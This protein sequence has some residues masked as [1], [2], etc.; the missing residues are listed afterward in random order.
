MKQTDAMNGVRGRNQEPLSPALCRHE[1]IGLA[2]IT[3][4][5][6]LPGFAIYPLPSQDGPQH[7]FT[8][9]ALLHLEDPALGFG[10]YFES[11]TPLSSQGFV[12]LLVGLGK[13]LPFEVAERTAVGVLLALFPLFGAIYAR[14]AH[15]PVLPVA[16]MLGLIAVGWPLAMGPTT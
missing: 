3:I 1:W 16:G 14:A 8:A 11:N 15:R 9:F 2:L 13:I 12:Y 5:T 7:I 10:R 4:L 6:A